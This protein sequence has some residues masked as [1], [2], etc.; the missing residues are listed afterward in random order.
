MKFP[1]VAA[2]N[3]RRR[4]GPDKFPRKLRGVRHA[5]FVAARDGYPKSACPYLHNRYLV[6]WR[7]AWQAGWNAGVPRTA[8]LKERAECLR[9]ERADAESDA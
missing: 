4:V 2:A 8:K 6:G 1:A 7:M 5:G 3:R 9:R